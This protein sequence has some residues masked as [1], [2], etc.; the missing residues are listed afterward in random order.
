MKS[1][2][3]NKVVVSEGESNEYCNVGIIIQQRC[4]IVQLNNSVQH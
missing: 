4:G 1:D 2:A 3:A